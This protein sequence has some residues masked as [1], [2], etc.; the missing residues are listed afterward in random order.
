MNI[1]TSRSSFLGFSS[2]VDSKPIHTSVRSRD[3]SSKRYQRRILRVTNDSSQTDLTLQLSEI[4]LVTVTDTN[5]IHTFYEEELLEK[6]ERKQIVQ[7]EKHDI[8][9]LQENLQRIAA[10]GMVSVPNYNRELTP[11]RPVIV[12]LGVGGF[13]RSH[14]A[15]YLDQALLNGSN[16]ALVGLGVLEF[17]KPMHDALMSQDHLYTLISRGVTKTEY[18][19]IGAM[20]DFVHSPDDKDAALERLADPQTKIVS[21]TITE[22][23]Y[24]WDTNQHLDKS[25]PLVL[26]DIQDITQPSSALGHIVAALKLRK[27]RGMK[28]FTVLS[29]DNMP[30]NG[31]IARTLCLELAHEVDEDLEAW[32]RT[33]VPFPV[34]MVDRITPM[35]AKTDIE[36]LLETTGIVDKWP[37]VA[38]EY[39]QWVI[40]DNFVDNERPLYEGF[41]ALVVDDVTSYEC[42]KIR[43]LNGGHSAL[44]YLGYLLGHRDVDLAVNDP[45]V[46]NFLSRFFA[47]V[48]NTV[49]DVPGV[50]LDAYQYDLI[51]RFANENIK[52]KLQRLAQDGSAKLYNTMKEPIEERLEEG[53]SVNMLALGVAGYARYM[54]GVDEEGVDI[55]ILDPLIESLLPLAVTMFEEIENDFETCNVEPT[56]AFLELVFGAE[57][58]RH[59]GFSG[60]V[61][62]WAC[63]LKVEGCSAVLE[64]LREESKL[65]YAVG[66]EAVDV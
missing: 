11:D 19:V 24:C 34:T 30:N 51:S 14:Q 43:L 36:S 59:S 7:Q 35:T 21:L 40:E 8:Y 4:P 32:I 47:E 46:A 13:H 56:I 38:E 49:P 15:Y 62:A 29:C 20:L 5:T 23:G 31:R 2:Y 55:I 50:N 48:V 63:R 66:A 28:P 64:A 54:T 22:K 39:M 60:A 26:A 52:D 16:W 12:H 44:S 3:S 65:N 10:N 61:L 1:V 58:S 27:E 18:S 45:R 57:L 17:D 42:M 9:L 37:V 41:G 33:H 6:E 25:N 53:H